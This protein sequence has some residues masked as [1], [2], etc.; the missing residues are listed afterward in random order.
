MRNT[1][2]L[3]IQLSSFAE[4]ILMQRQYHGVRTPGK[5]ITLT[6]RPKIKSQ[7]QIYR[8]GQSIFCLPHRPKL[9]GFFDLCVHWVSVVREREIPDSI[10]NM[11][12]HIFYCVIKETKQKRSGWYWV[13]SS[14]KGKAKVFETS[15]L[16]ASGTLKVVLRFNIL[17]LHKM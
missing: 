6:A 12:W 2:E 9:S 8:Y 4:G 15:F 1:R 14:W 10:C 11:T 16:Q 13:T 7:S 17:P 5:E 3:I